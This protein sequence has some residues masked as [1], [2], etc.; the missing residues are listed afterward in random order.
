MLTHRFAAVLITLATLAVS[1]CASNGLSSLSPA[2]ATS[3]STRSTVA[4]VT[5]CLVDAPGRSGID[6]V[7]EDMSGFAV[8]PICPMNAIWTGPEVTA[9]FHD[10]N[11]AEIS[12]NGSPILRVLAGQL[13]SGSGQEFVDKYLSEL[14]AQGMEFDPPK[15][16]ASGPPEEIG[17]Y[18]VTYFHM[19]VAAEGY[20]YADGPTVVIAH[21]IAGPADQ[22]AAQDALVK[23][24]DNIRGVR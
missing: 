5:D 24:L 11:V 17:G 22:E 6:E 16:L 13:R 19:F 4:G 1:G 8:T 14:S 18:P 21:F 15:I 20:A 2:T 7:F 9:E 12:E 23:I 3:S 10:L